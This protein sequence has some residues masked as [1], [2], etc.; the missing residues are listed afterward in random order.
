[1][2]DVFRIADILVEN[3]KTKYADEI[4]IIAFYGSYAKGT[5]TEKSDMDFFFIPRT[6]E[7]HKASIQFILDGIGFDFWPISW[8][9]AE[10]IA[11]FEEVIVPV[12]ADSKVLYSRSDE[13]LERFK[14]LR[15]KISSLCSPENRPIML[16]KAV[17]NHEKCYTHLY[18]LK[19]CIMKNGSSD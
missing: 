7:A 18:N 4:S 10:K 12:I 14:G 16:R 8:E 1:M 6:R 11:S 5:A 9:R 2:T 19:S 3:I 13:E 17:N 15:T